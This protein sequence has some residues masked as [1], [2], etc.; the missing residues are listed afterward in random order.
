M[1]NVSGT[2]SKSTGVQ[3]SYTDI[4]FAHNLSRSS[5]YLH[6]QI[7]TIRYKVMACKHLLQHA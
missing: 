1:G 6:L 7:L 5:V 4:V 3:V 2:P